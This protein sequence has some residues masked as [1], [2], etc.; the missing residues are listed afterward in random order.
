[1][2]KIV[3]IE[4]CAKYC[5]WDKEVIIIGKAMHLRAKTKILTYERKD[6]LFILIQDSGMEVYEQELTSLGTKLSKLQLPTT[7]K[8]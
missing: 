1:M 2:K 4:R 6:N 3:L 8:N 7:C 5:N